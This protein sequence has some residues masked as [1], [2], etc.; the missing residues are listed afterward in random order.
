MWSV[1]GIDTFSSSEGRTVGRDKLN[2]DATTTQIFAHFAKNFEAEMA[3]RIVPNYGKAAGPLYPASTSH[4]I[5]V[6][7]MKGTLSGVRWLLSSEANF[8]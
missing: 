2:C 1:F 8:Q 4:W 6:G 5:R 7:P 3:F